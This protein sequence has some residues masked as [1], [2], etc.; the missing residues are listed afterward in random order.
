M[1]TRTRIHKETQT[2]ATLDA[3]TFTDGRSLFQRMVTAGTTP[4]D[5]SLVPYDSNMNSRSRLKYYLFCAFS[6][7]KKH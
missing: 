7:W 4:I 3:S 5:S 2:G 1:Q 6:H